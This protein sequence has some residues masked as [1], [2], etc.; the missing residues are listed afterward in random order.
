MKDQTRWQLWLMVAA[1]AMLL[2][3]IIQANA[4]RLWGLG[5]AVTDAQ[6]LLPVGVALVVTTVLNGLLSAEMKARLVFLR[7]NH[8]LPGHR[9]FSEY[10]VRDPRVD[11]SLLANRRGTQPPTDPMEQNRSW[12]RLYKAVEN[13]P[14]IR[15]VHRDYLLLRD[16]AGLSVVFIVCCGL[17]GAYAISSRATAFAYFILLT[18]QFGLVRHAA[19]NYGIRFVTTVLARGATREKSRAPKDKRADTRRR[20]VKSPTIQPPVDFERGS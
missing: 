7:W 3:G 14:A 18:V 16:Y 1:N 5:G 6:N 11:I 15:Q 10:A 17:A 12:Y 8:A 4:I 20:P 2:Y 9:A 13:D 19:A